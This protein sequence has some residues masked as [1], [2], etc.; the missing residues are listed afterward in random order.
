LKFLNKAIPYTP[1]KNLSHKIN[2]FF[3]YFGGDEKKKKKK[4]RQRRI[5]MADN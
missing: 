5:L 2:L 3:V 4:K 1:L